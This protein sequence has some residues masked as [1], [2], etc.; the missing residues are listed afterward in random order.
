MV[1]IPDS[2]VERLKA[3]QV[4]LVAGLGCSELA[5]ALGWKS[6]VASLADRPVFAD[7]RAQ[8]A[9]FIA[10]GRLGDALA[11]VRDLVPPTMIEEALRRAFPAGLPLPD[12]LKAAAE[13]PW[14]AVVSTA[15]DDLWERALSFIVDRRDPLRVLVGVDVSARARL[16]GG[17]AALLHLFGRTA[18]PGSLC[19]GPADARRRLVPSAGL[20][21]LDQLR[22]RRSLVLVGFRPSDPD[23]VWLTSWLAAQPVQ[24]AP[25]RHFLFLDL[26]EE[27]DPD[28]EVAAWGLRTGL[29]V[30]P[31]LEGTAEALARLGK[32]SR[33]IV[34]Q[35]P[36]SDAEIDL[37]HWLDRWARDPADPEPR[38]VL[39]RAEAALR[40]EERWDGLVELL[41]RRL[42][43]QDDRRQQIAALGEVARIFRERLEAPERALT[44]EIVMLR[45][46]PTD[47]DLW[48]KLRVDARAAG[49]WPLLVAEAATVAQAAGVTPGAARIWSEIARIEREE[50]DH[51]DRALAAW[52]Q[53]LV[54]SPGQREARDAQLE[55]LR[56]LAL[57]ADLAA[58][59]LA[60]VAETEDPAQA[61]VRMLEAAEVFESGLHDVAGAVQTY[62]RALALAPD[63][64]AA[65]DALT[66]LYERQGRWADLAALLDRR[67]AHLSAEA[68][69]P[70]RHRRAEILA[71]HLDALS[72]AAEELESLAAG[73]D[74]AALTGLERIY[75]RAERHDDYLRTLERRAAAAPTPAERMEILRRLASEGE[76]RPD[77]LERAALALEEILEQEPRD[78][79]AFAA[80][81]R[82][83]RAAGRFAALAETIA[84][85]LEV[86]E[87]AE[88]KRELLY[89]LAQL[90]GDRLDD[91]ARAL[92]ALTAGQAAGDRREEI[93]EASAR[94]AE[95][96]ERW[97][98]CAAS[99]TSWA[100]VVPE[101]ALRAEVLVEA[102]R[103][104]I[105]RLGDTSAAQIVLAQIFELLPEH[106][107]ALA[108][109]A[110]VRREAGDHRGAAELYEKSAAGEAS[111]AERARLLTEAGTEALD[112]LRDE[113][114]AADL[115]T[116]A[117]AADPE[118]ASANQRLCDI[119]VRRGRWVEVE[120]L[121]DLAVARASD[122]A[123]P[124]RLADLETRRA[125]ACLEQGKTDKALTCLEAAHRLR[126]ELLPLLRTYADLRFERSEWKPAGELYGAMLRLHRASLPASETLG[127][128]RRIGRCRAEAGEID[129]ALE[130]YREAVA[131]DPK[132]AETLE[133]L[134]ALHALRGDWDAWVRGREALAAEAPSVERGARWEEIGDACLER[135]SDGARAEA[136]YRSAFVAD[137]ARRSVIEKL[138]AIYTRTSRFEPAIE[139]LRARARVEGDPSARAATYHQAAQLS[140]EPLNRPAEAAELLECCLEDAPGDAE[141]FEEL[142]ALREGMGDWPGLAKA[143]RAALD[144]LPQAAPRERR[145]RLWGRLGDLAL[146]RLFDRPLAM[147]AYEAAA[148]L[149][150][151]DLQRVETLAHVYD[152]IGPD[153]RERA[154]ATHQRLIAH[155]P[156][157]T[158][159]YLA[160]AK[161]FGETGQLDQQWCVAAT[162]SYLKKITPP[163]DDLFRRLRPPQVRPPRHP[164]SAESWLRTLHPDQDRRLDEIFA[165]ASP[166]LAAPAAQRAA[167]LGLPKRSRVDVAQDQSAPVRTLVLLAQTLG[168]PIPEV[169]RIEGETG[170]TTV[171][172]VQHRGGPRAV[173][174]LGPPTLRRS[175]F[176]LVFD[177]A[178]QVAFLRPAW[179]PKVALRTPPMLRVGLEALRLLVAPG[180]GRPGSGE[181][182]QLEAYLHRTVPPAVLAPLSEAICRWGEGDLREPDADLGRWLA[183]TDLSAARVA[184]V[185]TG[186]LASAAR[187][188]SSEP[189]P[190]SPIPAHK[191]MGDLIAF[192]VSE[193][194]FAC[195]R[196]LGLTVGEDRVPEERGRPR[197]ATAS[198]STVA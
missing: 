104:F 18:V 182:E 33:S 188:I 101:S 10:A 185:L 83:D 143:L 127:I 21:W 3:R 79:D 132:H 9:A 142:A 7:A 167:D 159:S 1:E 82:I 89:A 67:G 15:F 27:T 5:G 124:E 23:L 51:P 56:G 36:R 69:A 113:D 98:I 138:L 24:G 193:D 13:F 45:L 130:S 119:Y 80:L 46:L 2:L 49:A 97:T 186:E 62:E 131:L 190:L 198:R 151:D 144:R 196:Q 100:A 92:D 70:L 85:R 166:F 6:F 37:A 4:V 112:H 183:V 154:I 115:F 66:A 54:A 35:L 149:A 148:A 197:A 50:L 189:V 177:L 87:T 126:P 60:S 17:D 184:L 65:M 90:Y 58:A 152:V 171:L 128:L 12:N 165:I 194:Y 135:L 39:A 103:V 109:L 107:R 176:D 61:L 192:S 26:S 93:Y 121:L 43:L 91:P 136:A 57:W 81:S 129:G 75:G 158:D 19:L 195:R 63:D 134:A 179:F 108:L 44:A 175:S 164:L 8:V 156:H 110:R 94:M 59:L 173:L 117:L 77:G 16:G 150:P 34:A 146:R 42:D 88:A 78:A 20:A 99:L 47:D 160:L 84:R 14:R 114:R 25:V 170:Q 40:D 102:A 122:D 118:H 32:L 22:R 137:P 153:A 72:L 174:V 123:E 96:L 95:R 181:A 120:A 168:V 162:L 111:P 163:L 172:N 41:L 139:M 29:E 106:P 71:E 55:L 105:E 68:A 31:C 28:A 140:L 74:H 116:Q 187:V 161:L 86:T 52:E 73:G 48:E 53:A 141:A 145:L 157:R 133:A 191:R 155:D 169:Y 76:E 64:G 30:L 11:L 125:G 38:R 180:G 178:T 147:E